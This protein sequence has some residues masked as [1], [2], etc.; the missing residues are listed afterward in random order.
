MK[1]SAETSLS[2][3]EVLQAIDRM[4]KERGSDFMAGSVA[5]AAID[6]TYTRVEGNRFQVSRTAGMG[7]SVVCSGEVSDEQG[8]T[9]IYLS[10]T[11]GILPNAVWLVLGTLLSV[12]TAIVFARGNPLLAGSIAMASVA[13]FSQFA[14]KL[15]D[16]RYLR[17][18]ISKYVHR[19]SWT[20]R[21][22]R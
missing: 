19:L 16:A 7:P 8:K 14:V 4:P 13:S 2:V 20:S 6:R 3:E 12:V 5:G 15:I 17:A 21:K 18:E 10:T 1:H 22:D 11:Y 9:V